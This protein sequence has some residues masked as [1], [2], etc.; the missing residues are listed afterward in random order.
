MSEFA[1]LRVHSTFSLSEGASKVDALVKRAR[2]VGV[3]A[4]SLTDRDNLFG[5]ME[6]S[7]EATYAGI[8]PLVGCQLYIEYAPGKRGNVVLLAQDDE[9]YANLCALL[10]SVS[11][12]VEGPGGRIVAPE[13]MTLHPEELQ[14]RSAGLILLTGGG[15]DGLLPLMAGLPQTDGMDQAGEM[16]RW[17]LSVFGDRL[18]VEICRNGAPAQ[19]QADTEDKLIALAMGGTDPVDCADGIQRSQAPLVATSDVW[20]ASEDRHDAWRLLSAVVNKSSIAMDGDQIMGDDGVRYHLRPADEMEELFDDLPEAFANAANVAR[21]CAFSVQGRKPILPAFPCEG[22]RTESEELREQA[23]EGLEARL[24]KA[25]IGEDRAGP[26][27]ERL[28]YELR[29]IENMGFPGY[30][31]IV[32]DFIKW[33]KA[34]DIPVGPGRGSGA[35]SIV[36]W[37]LTITDLDPLEFNLLFERFL[38]PDRISMPDFDIDFCQDRRGEVRDYVKDKYGADRVALIATFGFIK[39][40]TALTDLQRILVHEQLGTVSFSEVKELTKSIPSKE[41]GAEPMELTE[42]YEKDQGFRDRIDGSDKLR[43]LFEQGLKIEGLIRSSGAHAAGVIIG[44]RPLDELVPITFD[45]D[46]G[47][48]VAGFNMKGVEA[49]GLVKFDFLGLTTLSVMRL[50]QDYIREFRGIDLDLATIP[51]DDPEV[52]ARLAEGHCTGVFQFEGGG[53]RKVMR[54]IMP[55]RFEDLI[56]IV[57]LFRPGPM[58]YIDDYASRKNGMEFEYPGG[59]ERTQSCLEETFGIMVYQEQ[60]MQVAQNVSG[61]SLGGADL[62]RRA[63]GK[64]DAKEMARQQ[65]IFVHGDDNASPP[66]AGAIRRGMSEKD[67]E[68]LFR[69]ILPF[70][71]YGFN[72]SHAAAYA[73]IGYQTAW[74]KTH[75]PAEYFSALMSYYTDKPEKLELIKDEL[76]SLGVP[77]LPPDINHSYPRFRPETLARAKGGLAVRFGLAAIKSISG[78]GANLVDLREKDGPFASLEEFHRRAG[79]RYNKAHYT[80]LAEAGAFDTLSQITSRHQASDAM[81]WLASVKDKAPAGQ[82]DMFGG[83]A[84]VQI[85]QKVLD[86]AEWGDIADREYKSVGFYFSRHPIDPYRPRLER[87][88]VRRRQRIFEYMAAQDLEQLEGRRLCV[89]VDNVQVRQTGNGRTY[90]QASVSERGDSYRVSCYE[91]RREGLTIDDFRSTLEGA[92][93]SRRPVVLL[94]SLSMDRDRSNV[95]V[96]GRAVWDIDDYLAEIRGNIVIKVDASILS[97]A[98]PNKSNLVQGAGKTP[99]ELTADALKHTAE[100]LRVQLERHARSDENGASSVT[101]DMGDSR[102]DLPG[103]FKLNVRLENVLRQVPGVVSIQDV[104]ADAPNP[105]AATSAPAA[106]RAA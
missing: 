6:F 10:R 90:V 34:H 97:V 27:R 104:A 32:S 36:A 24:E 70:A 46:A 95:W 74:L 58:A 81:G 3:P 76:D 12:P 44:D 8:Q 33:A 71:N 72:K 77:L 23:R 29:V 105:S 26:Y 91:N 84:A 41:E 4:M 56:A 16:Y 42:A 63:M 92:R 14:A 64:K 13:H 96:N 52:Y 68:Q 60:V 39:S 19:E 98:Q 86:V 66:V 15:T 47:M 87:A 103:P 102:I 40:K 62:L 93:T 2:Q 61:Y 53:M 48:P 28:D 21:R 101:I 55:T 106:R 43:V 25:G 100:S 11:E 85:P 69:D 88:G 20:Y 59:A 83:V 67:A 18:Y 37:G 82:A 50:A 38:N 94:A 80:R 1:H 30:F 22:G 7:K 54:K 9:G 17:L 65:K 99:A 31:L 35:G 51:R 45:A 75:Y 78:E 73:W 57:A 49:A 5:A 79:S 89:M